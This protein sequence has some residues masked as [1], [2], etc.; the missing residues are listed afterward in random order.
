[1]SHDQTHHDEPDADDDSGGK[2]PD[3]EQRRL[4]QALREQFYRAFT[5][6]VLAVITIFADRPIVIDP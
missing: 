2:D 6:G 5:P 3:S 4:P 1:M